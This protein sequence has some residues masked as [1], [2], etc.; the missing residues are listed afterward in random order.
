[1][2]RGVITVFLGLLLLC[3]PAWGQYRQS[4][5]QAARHYDLGQKHYN[6]GRYAEAVK[7]F[8]EA[9]RLSPHHSALFNVARC[10]ENQ[11]DR[12]KALEFY[13]QAL[14]LSPPPDKQA[15]IEFRVRKLLS[16]PVKVFVSSLPSGATVTVDGEEKP[17]TQA[18]PVVLKLPPGE[19]VLL[20][21]RQGHHL[22]ARRIVVQMD[23]ELPVEVK[24][25]PLPKACPLPPP[26]CPTPKPCPKLPSLVDAHN[27]HLHFTLMG[28]LSLRGDRRNIAAGPAVQVTATFR[29]FIFGGHFLAFPLGQEQVDQTP[30]VKI[31]KNSKASLRWLLGQVEAGYTFPFRNW[32]A[33]ATLGLGA[34]ADRVTFIGLDKD[35]KERRSV[36]EA[37]AFAWSVGGGA[38]AM[39][40][41]WISL[42]ASARFGL[43]HGDLVDVEDQT[44]TVEG[45]HVP[46]GSISGTITFHL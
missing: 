41:K 35:D 25:R 8:T 37:V 24:L 1:V 16:R 42:G 29:R 43:I 12:A 44:D 13:Q 4:L 6:G 23:K 39:I 26:P 20:V 45:Q 36:R 7:A 46:Y 9:H 33:Y 5:K 18:T 21:R 14:K 15:D 11:G 40:N 2:Q 31:V 27:L 19:H 38:E 22:E 10:Y 17:A 30:D 34:S 28:A 32:Y 3:G